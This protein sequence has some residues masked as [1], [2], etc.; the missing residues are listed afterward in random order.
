MTGGFAYVLDQNNLFFDRINPELIELHRISTEP[1]EAHRS[2]LRSVLREYVEGNRQRVGPVHP[3]Q[4]RC[5]EPQVLA[6]QAESRK[7]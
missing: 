6:G 1:M 4:L 7:P 2:H 5:H 3:G